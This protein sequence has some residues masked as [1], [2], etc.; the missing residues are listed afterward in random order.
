MEGHGRA[1]RVVGP[2]LWWPVCV[3]VRRCARRAGG[4]AMPCRGLRR[5]GPEK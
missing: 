2:G 3:A 4:R 5:C 1:P